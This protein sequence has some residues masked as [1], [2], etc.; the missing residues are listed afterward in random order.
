MAIDI[1]STSRRVVYTGSAGLGPYAFSFEVL[2]Q[3][4]IAVYLDDTELTLT[5]DY[6]VSLSADGTGSVTLVTGGSIASTPDAN[7][8]VTIVGDRTIQRT[9]DFT[10]GGPLF[11]ATL[12]DEFD[13]LTIFAQQNLEQSNRSLRAPNT[14]PTTVNMEL[15]DNTT[16]ANKTL[17]FDAN[18]D[19]VIGEQIGDYRGDWAASTSYNK[20][21]LVKDTTTNN[22]FMANT[23]HTSSGAEPLTTN[24]DSAKWDLIVDAASAT[25]SATNAAASATTATT[26]ATEAATSATSAATSATTATTKATEAATS[27]TNAATSATTA[28]T[29]ATEASTSATSAASS[30]TS[31]TSSA[32]TA[33]TKAS[34]ASTSATNAA[35]S[36][37]SASTSATTAT[38]QATT[39]TTKASE[40][41]TSA[42]NA[43]TSA[44]SASTAQTAAE[45]AQTAA[46][47]A[48][49]AAETAA[50][51]FDD[52]YLGAKS[53]D[54]STDND[55]DALTAGDLYFN[56]TSNNLKVYTGSAWADAAVT[57]ADFLTVSNNLSDLNNAS[58][59]R[60]NLGVAIGSDVQAFDA[61]TAKL[62][63]TTSNFTGDLQV[64]GTSVA[65]ETNLGVRNLVVNGDMRFAQRGTSTSSVSSGNT[66][67]TDRFKTQ[68][69]TAGTWTISQDTDVPSGQGFYKSHK[70]DCTTA[71]ASLSS[72]SYGIFAHRMEGQM[73]QH[74][75]KGTSSAEQTTLSFWV[76]SNKTGTY[77][78]NLRDND[79]ARLVGSEYTISSANTW[80]KKTITFAADTSGALDNDNAH[81][82]Q[83]EYWFVAGSTYSGGTAPS[84]WEASDNTDRAA[85]IVN[86]ADSTSNYI[87]FTG[88]QL[89]VGDTATPFEHRPYEMELAR[90]QRYYQKSYNIDVAPGTNTST[91]QFDHNF[92]NLGNYGNVNQRFGVAMRANPTMTAY[93]PAGASG[94][95]QYYD[96]SA[97]VTRTTNFTISGSQQN[98]NMADTVF[99]HTNIVF[100]W[101]AEAEL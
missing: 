84:A 14:D 24:T 60:T 34:E 19:P 80:E 16:R 6:T 41:A 75:K 10:T 28:S 13:S 47:A 11:A 86:L 96:G 18:G 22:I 87:N 88:I 64:S 77:Q 15:P 38:T 83:V 36:A 54:P 98:F 2:A 66:F 69:G 50:D 81:S 90:C 23:A 44:T 31:A 40:A 71:N 99:N 70:L 72:G 32:T 101:T 1:S 48:Q 35:T 7:D 17:A 25:T 55:G 20:R 89:E 52:V 26:K 37:T 42:T 53:S 51:N 39:A 9:T 8:R 82:L 68:L 79:N 91:G 78:V 3:T 74:L 62:D 43:A 94:T 49:A 12:N 4:D 27:A 63:A 33:T 61:D 76:K 85:N 73:L 65:T 46:E 59:A 5:T 57:A 95:I 67:G 29:K 93:S 45:T 92:L 30:A 58:T 21:D 97:T 100:Q 56:T